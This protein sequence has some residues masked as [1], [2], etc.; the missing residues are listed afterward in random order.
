MLVS[1]RSSVTMVSLV[2]VVQRRPNKQGS[3]FVGIHVIAWTNDIINCIPGIIRQEIIVSGKICINFTLNVSPVD[4]L[5]WC[6]CAWLHGSEER[7]D[8]KTR[9]KSLF[10]ADLIDT[11]DA[12]LNIMNETIK[13]DVLFAASKLPKQSVN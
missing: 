7:Y 13:R 3:D 11:N 9:E 12:G 1:S 4:L 6:V 2:T 10:P 8:R 5:I